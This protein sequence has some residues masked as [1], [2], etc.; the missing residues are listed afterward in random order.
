MR[1]EATSVCGLQLLLQVWSE[2]EHQ[3]WKGPAPQIEVFYDAT[4]GF[5]LQAFSPFIFFSFSRFSLPAT[6]D[7][8]GVSIK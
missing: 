1:P 2:E 3:R 5:L 4:N 8:V 6:H 7:L